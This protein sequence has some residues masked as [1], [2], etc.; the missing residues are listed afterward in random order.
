MIALIV[1]V[2][3]SIL[4]LLEILY[5]YGRTMMELKL[6]ELFGENMH[7]I[8]RQGGEISYAQYVDSV[9]RVQLNMFLDTNVGRRA[10]GFRKEKEARRKKER[11]T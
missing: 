3:S 10:K 1:V 7:E 4:N 8:G 11:M 5:R 6:K 2:I 9:D